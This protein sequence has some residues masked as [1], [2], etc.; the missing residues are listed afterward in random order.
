ME[1]LIKS[2]ITNLVKWAPSGSS[3][4]VM[5]HAL[6]AQDWLPAI[7]ASFL[8]ACS[9]LWVK[10]SGK[11]MEEAEKE[12]EKRG[13]GLAK[14][15][16][17][18]GDRTAIA[19]KEKTLSAWRYVTSDF[20]N[21]Y[22]KRLTYICRNYEKQGL[23]K[24][25]VLRLQQVFVP[26]KIS[27]KSLAKISP[28]LIQNSSEDLSKL[29]DIGQILVRMSNNYAFRR[30]AILG[31]P[32]S[33]KTTLLRYLTLA[34]I[35]RQQRKLLNS[36]VPSFIPVLIYLRDVR[37]EI[38]NN[39]KLPL[40]NLIHSW[41]Q[42]LQEINPLNPPPNWV[43]NKIKHNQFLILLDGLDEIA[44][45]AERQQVSRWVD[46]QMKE[47]PEIAFILSSR[48]LGYKKAKLKQNVTVLEVQPFSL[49][50]VEQFIHNWYLETEILRHYSNRDEGVQEIAYRQAKDLV[51][52]IRDNPP[53]AT[54][55]VNPLL[56]TMIATV[57]VRGS[58]LPGKRVELYK[59]IF[60]VLLEKRQRAKG[61]SDAL[62]SS[63]KL[64]VLKPLAFALMEDKKRSFSLTP[65]VDRL[66]Q[67]KLKSLSSNISTQADFLEQIREASGL[68]IAKEE[69]L[70]EFAHLSFQ[71]YLASVEIKESNKESIL[72][73]ALKSSDQLSWWAETIRLYCAQN[74]ASSII[75]AAL[76]SENIDILSLAFDCLE[77]GLSVQPSVREKLEIRLIQG[78]ESDDT[79]LFKVAAEVKLSRRLKQLLRVDEKIAI[80]NSYISCA[81]YQLFVDEQR[82]QEK[83]HQPDHWDEY[84]FLSS[85]ATEPITGVR[86][87]DAQAFCEWLS[88]RTGQYYRLPYFQEV[89]VHPIKESE[90]GAWS[91]DPDSTECKLLGISA[92]QWQQ[93]QS[94]L[95]DSLRE[96]LRQD[97][98]HSNTSIRAS[99]RDRASSLALVRDRDRDRDLASDLDSALARVLIRDRHRD[100][101]SDLARVLI[102]ERG[103]LASARASASAHA[104]AHEG[105][106]LDRDL[107]RVLARASDRASDLDLAARA[108]DSDLARA[109]DRALE[110]VSA[111]DRVNTSALTLDL[112]SASASASALA[113]DLELASASERILD[114][115]RNSVLARDSALA[116]DLANDLDRAFTI[117]LDLARVRSAD[118][119]DRALDSAL[120]L[121]RA[122]DHDSALDSASDHASIRAYLSIFLLTLELLIETYEQHLKSQIQIFR[123]NKK[124]E[125]YNRDKNNLVQ[126][127]NTAADAYLT[128]AILHLRQTNQL[129]AWESIRI[130]REDQ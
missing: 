16:F 118:A 68:L 61:I 38:V 44:D 30:L 85:K 25:Q 46:F 99:V 115:S 98:A 3:F 100:R 9:V 43:A 14:W 6:L 31:A 84:H 39:P 72:T 34:Y 17:V 40:V 15:M 67:E 74:D 71:E 102:R 24:D 23:D 22:Y 5:V 119:L 128:L 111:S 116:R 120:A 37:E 36:R 88:L 60:Q 124:T 70:Y 10:F 94:A 113:R 63:Q 77:E 41:L 1:K 121:A 33:G 106:L 27:Q 90:I 114:R 13:G 28:D 48:P 49:D 12:A 54:M 4:G 11:F 92:K 75:Q 50:Q 18:V 123:D 91:Q 42:K 86:A 81:E 95:T 112:A 80:D 51:K 107:D 127:F 122:S 19:L 130:V 79:E 32:G 69:G 55:A 96:L 57:H 110:L 66:L 87:S 104:H 126:Q 53:L 45:E 35:S 65:E 29:Q 125:Q 78:L 83:Y 109:L 76:S 73:S 93:W 8:T 101:A 97:F 47:Y 2:I 103:D 129:P 117:A 7:L 108:R 62:R 21:E 56:L 64:S 89:Q 20:E 59:E 58:A 105:V 82:E 26:L 52:R